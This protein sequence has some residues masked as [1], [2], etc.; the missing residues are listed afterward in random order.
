MTNT[1][2]M[3]NLLAHIVVADDDGPDR[4]TAIC[5]LKSMLNEQ[6][7]KRIQDDISH[8]INQLL[9][10]M[11]MPCHLMGYEAVK[12]AI[13]LCVKNPPIRYYITEVYKLVADEMGDGATR[14]RVERAMRHAIATA[15]ERGDPDVLFKHFGSTIPYDKDK[16]TNAEFICTM[17]QEIQHRM[18]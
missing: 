14:S 9:L 5:E 10:E 4:N 1:E 15:W 11:G 6:K 8:E 7:D 13:A 18:N 17:A 12:R 2:K 16:P 3:L